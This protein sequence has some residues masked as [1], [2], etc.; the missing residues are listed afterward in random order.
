M[1]LK[2]LGIS[3]ITG[4]ISHGF[5]STNRS[6]LL[7]LAGIGFFVVGTLL[8][9]RKSEISLRQ[10]I[11]GVGLAIGIGAF[12][13]GLQHFPESAM[14]S[15]WVVPVGFV[16]SLVFIKLSQGFTVTQRDW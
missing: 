5:F 1:I 8:E 13:G 4:A 3:L 14:R 15:L 11:Y 10:V 16:I 6:L 9:E 12:A 2:Y 7:A